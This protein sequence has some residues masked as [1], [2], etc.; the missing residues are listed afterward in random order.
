MSA[1]SDSIVSPKPNSEH[2]LNCC[3]MTSKFVEHLTIC[4]A[5]RDETPHETSIFQTLMINAH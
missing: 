3:E 2:P 4:M 5:I 1:S